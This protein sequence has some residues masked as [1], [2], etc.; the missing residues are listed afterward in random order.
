MSEPEFVTVMGAPISDSEDVI[1]SGLHTEEPT[2][3]ILDSSPQQLRP[4]AR[5]DL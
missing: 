2:Y 5:R 4:V 3:R 1:S